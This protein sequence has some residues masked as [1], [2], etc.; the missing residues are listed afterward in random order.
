MNKSSKRRKRT[1]RAANHCC[2]VPDSDVD[3]ARGLLRLVTPL[4]SDVPT[5]WPPKVGAMLR[6][7]TWHAAGGDRVKPVNALLYVLAVF[8][9]KNGEKRI[10]TAERFPSKRRWN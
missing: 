1:R 2:V 9:D 8:E 3:A 6:H 7:S 4:K 5:W 10:V